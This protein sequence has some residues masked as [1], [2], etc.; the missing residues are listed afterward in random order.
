MSRSLQLA[1]R[2]VAMAF[3]SRHYRFRRRSNSLARL[4]VPPHSAH[5]AFRARVRYRWHAYFDRDLSVLYR[6]TRRGE[7]VYVCIMPDGTGDVVPE[8]MFDSAVCGCADLG[9]PQVSVATLLDLRAL[10]MAIGSDPEPT[11]AQLPTKE[12]RNAEPTRIEP[13]GHVLAAAVDAHD[14]R[15]RPRHI[16][17]K[18]SVSASRPRLASRSARIALTLSLDVR[19]CLQSSRWP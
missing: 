4:Q 2:L 13:R 10:L 5:V 12:D 9:T 3:H 8:W 14:A 6:E 17:T 16:A 18:R 7:I 11:L 19:S 15:C 1:V